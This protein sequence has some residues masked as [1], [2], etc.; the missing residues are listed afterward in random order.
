MSFIQTKN[1][2]CGS[3]EYQWFTDRKNAD[4]EKVEA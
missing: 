3:L 1:F 2:F 4:K